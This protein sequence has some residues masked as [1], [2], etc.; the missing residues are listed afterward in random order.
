MG[1]PSTAIA[2]DGPPHIGQESLNVGSP[3]SSDHSAPSLSQR[4]QFL[5]RDGTRTDCPSCFTSESVWRGSSF[6]R[7]PCSRNLLV[8]SRLVWFFPQTTESVIVRTGT[9]SLCS[10]AG[11]STTMRRGA[12]PA[13]LPT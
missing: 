4:Y 13:S 7:C 8:Q 9:P 2:P 6:A 5:N 11:G 3:T 12:E 10:I 1:K